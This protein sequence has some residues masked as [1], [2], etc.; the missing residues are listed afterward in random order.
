MSYV[1]IHYWHK[2]RPL[3]VSESVTYQTHLADEVLQMQNF[4]RCVKGGKSI[5][6]IEKVQ[7]MESTMVGIKEMKQLVLV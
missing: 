5:P 1:H 7:S 2:F 3:G 4:C 6:G